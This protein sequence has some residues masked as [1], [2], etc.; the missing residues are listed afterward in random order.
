MYKTVEEIRKTTGMNQTAFSESIGV[1]SRRT[2]ANR[3]GNVQPWILNEIIKVTEFNEGQVRV[4]AD[5]VDY[6]VDIKEAL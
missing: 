5:G 2:Y 1:N 3:I 4:T 6:L